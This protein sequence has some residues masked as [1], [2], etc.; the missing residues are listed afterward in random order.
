MQR[1]TGRAEDEKTERARKRSQIHAIIS[2]LALLG[3]LR[4]IL[5]GI[6]PIKALLHACSCAFGQARL[7]EATWI[8]KRKA[9][10]VIKRER[11]KRIT[12][13][14]VARKTRLTLL[15]VMKNGLQRS[16]E[17]VECAAS[18]PAFTAF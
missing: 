13:G 5:I 12:F 8:M 18:L 15:A 16:L 7:K 17:H 4:L 2:Y 3:I 6:I 11:R 14:K 1:G 9:Q 10:G